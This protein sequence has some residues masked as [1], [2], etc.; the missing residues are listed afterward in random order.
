MFENLLIVRLFSQLI[1]SALLNKS[2]K[3]NG[4]DGIIAHDSVFLL[5][6]LLL[7][8]GLIYEHQASEV[9]S[10]AR[11]ASHLILAF[12]Q[13]C[14]SSSR[15]QPLVVSG[16]FLSTQPCNLAVLRVII[17]TCCCFPT[18]VTPLVL[19]RMFESQAQAFRKG[20]GDVIIGT[21]F[22]QPLFTPSLSGCLVLR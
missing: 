17:P 7:T 11:T 5:P 8:E 12:G 15:A 22:Y 18:P 6:A 14:S 9:S 13:R 1:V 4:H 2:L 20:W 21:D 3:V 10:L 19:L 16:A